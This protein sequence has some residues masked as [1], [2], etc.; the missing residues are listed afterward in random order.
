L[1]TSDEVRGNPYEEPLMSR[2]VQLGR[3]LF[4][5]AVLGAT[6]APFPAL[7]A[8]TDA[9]LRKGAVVRL[10]RDAERGQPA[11]EVQ[12][13][14][15]RLDHDSVTIDAG[16]PGRPR[17]VSIDLHSRWRLQALMGSESHPGSGALAGALVGA[18]FGGAIGAARCDGECFG[19]DDLAAFGGA[20]LGAVV[21]SLLG[22][23]AGSSHET[24]SWVPIE[25]SGVRVALDPA[26]LGFRVEF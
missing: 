2:P 6:S 15:V 23:A 13:R 5:S 9:P 1:I 3:A 8:Q 22:L 16:E 21:G 17:L 14:L 4:L 20:G 12:G 11:R 25:T 7:G 26:R 24:G 10:V 18:L 19:G